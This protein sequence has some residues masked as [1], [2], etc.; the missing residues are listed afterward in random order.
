MVETAV[1][2]LLDLSKISYH[3]ILVELPCFTVDGDMPVVAMW[4]CAFAAVS[5]CEMVAG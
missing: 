3:A 4:L 2:E 5:Q 1:D